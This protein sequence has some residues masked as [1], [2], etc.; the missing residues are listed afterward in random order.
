[1]RR[2]LPTKL[3]SD[4]SS[5]SGNQYGFPVN[6]TKNILQVHTN[7]VSTQEIFYRDISHRG[8]RY[9]SKNQ[10]VHTGEVFQFTTGFITDIQNITALFCRSRRNCQKNLI[11]S[12][13]FNCFQDT[14]SSSYNRNI[15]NQSSPLVLVIVDNTYHVAPHF[16]GTMNVTNQHLSCCPCPNHHNTRLY[17]LGIDF[18]NQ[19]NKAIGKANPQNRKILKQCSDK[20]IGNRHSAKKYG[21]SYYVEEGADHGCQTDSKQLRVTGKPPYTLI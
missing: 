12:K 11:D 18:P 5:T 14:F 9:F 17:S 10:L 6:K 4:A 2:Y 3:R 15:V 21:N 20:I 1:M 8:N 16:T 19:K 13:L 7:R